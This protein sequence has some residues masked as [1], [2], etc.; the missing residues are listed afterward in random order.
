MYSGLHAKYFLFLSGFNENLVFS[1][2]FRKKKTSVKTCH[3]NSSGGSRVV[4][5]GRTD[6]QA[7]MAKVTVT[8]RNFT[9]A[10]KSR[11]VYLMTPFVR[12]LTRLITETPCTVSVEK[13][14][15]QKAIHFYTDFPFVVVVVVV[16]FFPSFLQKNCRHI[17]T[18]F[19][20]CTQTQLLN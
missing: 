8:F 12:L 6:R 13:P 3:E 4:S 15:I 20:L 17:F 2:G 10:P 1:T 7:Y 11:P 14:Q 5:C 16:R 18:T 9:N 19:F